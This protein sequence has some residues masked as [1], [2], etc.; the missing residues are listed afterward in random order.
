MYF[1][2]IKELHRTVSLCSPFGAKIAIK[3]ICTRQLSDVRCYPV[4]MSK[5]L[6][7]HRT[8]RKN[9]L[10]CPVYRQGR[11]LLFHPHKNN[12]HKP[13]IR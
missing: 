2:E 3:K 6:F 1:G 4:N 7:L 10:D 11:N 8:S 9:K 12:V 5:K 13:E